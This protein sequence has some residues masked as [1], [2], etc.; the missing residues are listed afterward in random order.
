MQ[1]LMKGVRQSKFYYFMPH[2]FFIA[3]KVLYFYPRRIVHYN[4]DIYK[5][6][7]NT[8]EN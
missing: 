3:Q 2:K 4:Y 7:C 6:S 8:L 5:G 1:T